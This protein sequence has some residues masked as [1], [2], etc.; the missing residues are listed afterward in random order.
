[1]IFSKLFKKIKKQDY[2]TPTEEEDY[3]SSH[4]ADI[5]AENVVQE[6]HLSDEAASRHYVVD[7]CEQMIDVS[8]ELEDARADYTLLTNY[9]NDIQ[10]I[11]ELTP[12][13][14]API[15]DCANH[16]VQ[17]GKQKEDFLN[18]AHKLSETQFA[19][20]QQAEE[21]LPG[22]IKRLQANETYLEAIKRDL[23]YLDGEKLEWLM[24]KTDA[25]RKQKMIRYFSIA[26]FFLFATVVA[27]LLVLSLVNHRDTRIPMMILTGVTAVLTV[28]LF[29]IYQNASGDIHKA[30]VNRNRAITLENHVKIKYVN[31]KNAV[32]Y[33]CETY[34]ARDSRQLLEIYELYQE[35]MRTQE[36]FRQTNEELEYYCNQLIQF[37]RKEH[38]YDAKEWI[39]HANAL[40]DSREMVEL[41]HDLIVRRQKTRARV[42]YNMKTISNMKKEALRYVDRMGDRAGKMQE[43]INRIEEIGATL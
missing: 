5:A 17:L 18:T 36:Q 35:E 23:K 11:E 40:L 37:L 42:E 24:Q 19:Q 1:M 43:L 22:V 27:F 9:L 6:L 41:K 38:L 20:M 33:T 34:H 28:L 30:D 10:R 29:V 4:Y 32:D 13:Q 3:T 26:L 2:E 16:L 25:K 15:T 7:L 14:K 21:E 12:E 31:I 8:R 39:S